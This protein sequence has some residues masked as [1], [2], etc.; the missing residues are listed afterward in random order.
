MQ[1]KKLL[2]RLSAVLACLVLVVALAVPCFADETTTTDNSYS[3]VKTLTFTDRPTLYAWL[4]EN[5]SSVLRVTVVLDGFP[6]PVVYDSIIILVDETVTYQFSQSH[7]YFNDLISSYVSFANVTD[8][9]LELTEGYIT[10]DFPAAN[11]SVP[12]EAWSAWNI[13]ATVVYLSEY[14]ESDPNAPTRSGLFGELY[15]I[16]RDALYG[17]NAVL[18]PTQEFALTQVSTWMTYI[19]IL[20]PFLVVAIILFRVFF[21]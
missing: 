9:S 13:S 18:D 20:L 7:F 2:T 17:K 10:G 4:N 11:S 14:E 16:I 8:S 3:V 21:R 1:N 12:D 15:Y 19:V 5:A 6:K